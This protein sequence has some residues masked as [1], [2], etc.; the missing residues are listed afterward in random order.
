MT[1]NIG[2]TI[3]WIIKDENQKIL[4]DRT[5]TV[6]RVSP[7][8]IDLKREDQDPKDKEAT[9]RVPVPCSTDT[10]C[11]IGPMLEKIEARVKQA[12]GQDLFAFIIVPVE[13]PKSTKEVPNAK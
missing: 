7:E 13:Q 8:T 5:V 11:D 12:M 1:R 6:V 4:E 3:H 9:L 10:N 2:E